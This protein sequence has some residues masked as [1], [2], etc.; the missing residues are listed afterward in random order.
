[1]T[2]AF[3]LGN[4]RSRQAI[5]PE[6][7]R[8]HG[9]IYA[10]NAIYREFAPDVLV[11]TDRPIA[12]TIQNSGYALK[13][14]FHTRRPEPESGA[15]HLHKPYMGF[16]S[17]PNAVG[18]ACRDGY[19]T[20]YMLGFDLGTTNGEFNNVFADTEFYKKSTDPPTF[21]GNWMRQILQICNDHPGKQ[22][23]RVM[24]K[25]SAHAPML[26]DARNLKILEISDFQALLNSTKGVL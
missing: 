18:L 17:G 11:A 22:F 12:M 14:R 13:H 21:A 26:A 24:G 5:D 1:M 8:R 23:I 10:C 7:L 20:I 4:G 16:S 2:T 6:Q 9:P 3:V 19:E 25:E 15:L